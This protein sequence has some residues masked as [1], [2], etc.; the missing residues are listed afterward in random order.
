M[1][2]RNVGPGTRCFI[3]GGLGF[4]GSYLV[5]HLLGMKCAI[6]VYDVSSPSYQAPS[7]ARIRYIRGDLSDK[8]LLAHVLPG[9]DVVFHLAAYTDVRR[10]AMEPD[11]EFQAGPAATLNL[12]EMMRQHRISELVFTSS[13][14][15]YGA[16]HKN[17]VA[18]N[19]TP[20]SPKSRYGAS[21]AACETII[22]SYAHIYG[23]K[24]IICRLC[25]IVGGR[26]ERGIIPD[27][28][29]RITAS[30]EKL[31]LEQGGSQN[32]S[33]LIAEYAVDGILHAYQHRTEEAAQVYNVSNMDT[34]SPSTVA[35]IVVH[36]LGMDAIT[37][38]I[39]A[40]DQTCPEHG[41][42]LLLDSSK[43]RALGW[44]SPLNSEESVRQVVRQ[45][46]ARFSKVPDCRH[47]HAALTASSI[48]QN[49]PE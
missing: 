40:A 39:D 29:A 2:A 20:S 17:P 38:I 16:G 25:N 34:I 27:L 24:A 15:V 32:R 49:R 8:V 37:N 45:L 36:E 31:V 28:I 35:R 10:A 46:C 26:M 11:A 19:V 18:E 23:L 1:N 3:T 7:G 14:L 47:R 4:I 13:Q 42:V 33:Y 30:P 48:S 41:R 44:S 9:H 21:K 43:L 12:L 6:T 22:S 5:D